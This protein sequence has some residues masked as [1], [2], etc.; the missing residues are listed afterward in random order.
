M[1]MGSG[2]QRDGWKPQDKGMGATQIR[3]HTGSAWQSNL[4]VEQDSEVGFELKAGGSPMKGERS[5]KGHSGVAG[6]TWV[7]AGQQTWGGMRFLW[8]PRALGVSPGRQALASK[9]M[10][11]CL[12][13]GARGR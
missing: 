8:R 6:C 13:G 10:A 4:Q 1:G 5:R 11:G 9:E 2:F 7:G 12:G 3:C